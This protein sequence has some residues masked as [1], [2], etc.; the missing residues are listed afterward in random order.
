M[1]VSFSNCLYVAS[2]DLCFSLVQYHDRGD[3]ESCSEVQLLSVSE[4]R[5]YGALMLAVDRE[6]SYSAFYPYPFDISLVCSQPPDSITYAIEHVRPILIEKLTE[7]DK[8]PTG[9]AVPALN[10]YRHATDIPLPPVVG[11]R[12]YDLRDKG[13]D[14]TM[15][16]QLYD[17]I[18][19]NDA[20]VLR[21]LST[22]I[23]AGMLHFHYQFFEEATNTLY[24]SM[25]ASYRMVLRKLRDTGYQQPTAKD[26]ANYIH[27]AFYDIDRLEKYFE[28]DYERRIASFHPES[29]LGIFS[30]PPITADD[31]Y[32][33][34]NDLLEVYRYLLIGYVHPKHLEKRAT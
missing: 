9:Y 20:I 17:A 5:I 22:L 10:S 24:I 4:I 32:F 15:A 18:C 19:P 11:G 3:D 27:N 6:I 1:S 7:P 34:F 31:Y 26:A 14:Y 29:R 8:T 30:H 33:L 13:I 2:R 16:Q 28:E 21:G 25:E 23:K 12:D